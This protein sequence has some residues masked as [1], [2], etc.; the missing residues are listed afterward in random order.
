M[1]FLWALSTLLVLLSASFVPLLQPPNSSRWADPAAWMI[2]PDVVGEQHHL[3]MCHLGDTA[4]CNMQVDLPLPQHMLH[5]HMP[6]PH[7][8]HMVPSYLMCK[9]PCLSQQHYSHD[10]ARANGCIQSAQRTPLEC[11]HW[12]IRRIA[13]LDP[14]GGRKSKEPSLRDN[15]ELEEG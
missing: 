8:A 5:G 7:A 11:Q 13:F 1:T 2:M 4:R 10:P 6:L 12:V 14:T 9:H 3:P 15:Q